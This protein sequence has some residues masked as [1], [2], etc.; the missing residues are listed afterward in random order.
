MNTRLLIKRVGFC[1]RFPAAAIFSDT[2]AQ[3]PT[4]PRHRAS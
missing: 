1:D 4:T 2:D 3:M